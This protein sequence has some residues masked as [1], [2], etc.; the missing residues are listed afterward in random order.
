VGSLNG[1]FSGVTKLGCKGNFLTAAVGMVKNFSRGN[2]SPS[3]LLQAQSR[4]T[5]LKMVAEMMS[6]STLFVFQ[7]DKLTVSFFNR[8]DNAVDQKADRSTPTAGDRLEYRPPEI[9][10]LDLHSDEGDDQE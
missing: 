6:H 5:K 3:T 7:R 1:L 10:L 8:I 2:R 9:D 4:S